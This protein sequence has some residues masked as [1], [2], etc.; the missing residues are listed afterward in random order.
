MAAATAYA[1]ALS[2]FKLPSLVTGSSSHA[3]GMA[4]GVL[5]FGPA[6]MALSGTIV[7]VFQ[8]LVLALGG[9]TTLGANA[10][11][12]AV[13]GPWAAFAAIKGARAL[14][15]GLTTVAFLAGF[16]GDLFT[17]AVTA[18]QLA[19]AFPDPAS[20]VV[21]AYAKFAA[22]YAPTQLP[23]ALAEGMLTAVVAGVLTRQGHA[24]VGLPTKR[25]AA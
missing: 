18:G 22:V 7:L 8:A 19:L 11:A 6:P 21:G 16:L 25:A 24:L 1:F 14:G 5:L 2:A 15:L 13:I 12:M 17:Y 4:L 23:L 3:T 10:M 9:L 20:G